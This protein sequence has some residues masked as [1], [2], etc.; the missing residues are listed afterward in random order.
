M[1]RSLFRMLH[2]RFGTR[3]SGKERVR[4]AREHHE[5]VRRVIPIGVLNAAPSAGASPGSLAIV[6][7]GFAGAAAA[8]LASQLGFEDTHVR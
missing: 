2:R 1:G 6:G 5:R 8:H 4:R 3:I 7:A